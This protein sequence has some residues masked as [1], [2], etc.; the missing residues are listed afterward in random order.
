MLLRDV[1]HCS[2]PCAG[3]TEN[4]DA[5]LVRT[6]GNT[7]L[8]AV[9]DAL[10]HGP[11]AAEVAARGVA[12]LEAVSLEDDLLT[13]M[14]A[15]H[16]AL[17]GTRGAAVTSVLVRPNGVAGCAVGNVATKSFGSHLDIPMSPGILGA[18]VRKM[19]VFDFARPSRARLALFSDGISSR[20]SLEATRERPAADACRELLAA[21]GKSSDDATIL[22]A[23]L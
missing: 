1:A 19:R 12:C 6:H 17:Q 15:L 16:G 22:I 8:L 10:G 14:N 20:F 21:H 3:E 9:I 23:D 4:G 13:I 2:R 5:A 11:K 7:T 18:R